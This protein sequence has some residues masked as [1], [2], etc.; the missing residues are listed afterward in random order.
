M[1]LTNM[2][3]VHEHIKADMQWCMMKTR[4]HLG[5]WID[6]C[7]S[8]KLQ[9]VVTDSPEW[10]MIKMRMRKRNAAILQQQQQLVLLPQPAS[11]TASVITV[12]SGR[13]VTDR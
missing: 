4:H 6:V 2:H 3:F 8:C 12:W 1:L 7:F 11:R 13:Q 5:M 9:K 10:L